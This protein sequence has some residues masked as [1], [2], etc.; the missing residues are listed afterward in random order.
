[1]KTKS[2]MFKVSLLISVLLFLISAVYTV[3]SFVNTRDIFEEENREQMEMIISA[4]NSEI[5]KE[6][7]QLQFGLE[8]ILKN[9]NIIKAFAHRDR[10][11]LAQLTL[12]T[13]NGLRELG[14]EQFQFHLPDGSSFFR[15]HK[16]EKYG[17]DLSSFRF[18]VVDANEKQEI[19]S[20]LEGG[21][22]GAGFRYVVPVKYYG[23]HIGTVELGL[24]L[25]KETLN[26]FKKQFQGEWYY[27]AVDDNNYS[28]ITGTNE[29]SDLIN[30]TEQEFKKILNNEKLIYSKDQYNVFVLP[31]ED[32]S[33]YVKWFL[34]R[35]ED[36]TKVI[37]M[38]NDSL[39]NNVIFA[40]VFL[41]ISIVISLFFARR[42]MIKP[43]N[44]LAEKIRKIAE[45][46]LT[47]E[48]ITV[49][50][51]DEIGQLSEDINIMTANLKSLMGQT[52]NTSEQVA[53]TSEEL[54]ASS[55]QTSRAAE[56]I[57]ES[58]Q[59]V[60]VSVEKQANSAHSTFDTVT[61]ISNEIE[62][63]AEKIDSMNLFSQKT[64]N[65]AKDGNE[66]VEKAIN[67][68]NLINDKVSI[69]TDYVNSLGT[70]SS[71]IG[72]ITSIITDIAEQTNLLALN[73]AIEAARA[74]EHGKGFAVVADEVRKLA[75]QSG[76][77]AG[78][79]N[80]LISLMQKETQN[81]V[82]AMNVGSKAV[83]EGS[84]M[85]DNAGI[86]FNQITEAVNDVV[87]QAEIVS[88]AIIQIKSGTKEMVL[89]VKE[90]A[91]ISEQVAA[92]SQNVAAATEEQN[93]SMEEI[94]S[95]ANMLSKAAMEL[96]D[97]IK[98]FKI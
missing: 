90:I 47:G 62:Q 18:T 82:A 9:D 76:E 10:V 83:K 58:I 98:K 70:R 57:A 24:G 67:R 89:S 63:I 65:T 55:E 6:Y 84:E 31:L 77:A 45:G 11:T 97:S 21:V 46:D 29:E 87:K 61:G 37:S 78:K 95:A 85:V 94:T 64:L 43:V 1:M 40:A 36:G 88:A 71:E 48:S 49:K 20:G 8:P 14:V 28:I 74:G 33:K 80:E 79:I 50:S 44:L 19:T 81:A 5:E 54:T 34:V 93:A 15:A 73:A 17:D 30:F 91:G 52:A 7:L 26:Y 35:V 92:N 22:A 53:A 41:L 2:L 51:K 42:I 69:S 72:E 27:Y 23:S 38:I 4:V 60:A 96:H 68:M 86:A 16:P 32:Y 56:Q 75:V 3:K 25:N 13:M 59:E 66:V 39:I 12:P